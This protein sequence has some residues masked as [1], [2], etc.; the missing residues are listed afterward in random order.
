MKSKNLLAGLTC[1]LISVL[2]FG[3]NVNAE[4]YSS[5]K[6]TK[7]GKYVV[8][9]YD[10]LDWDYVRDA[11]E[12]VFTPEKTGIYS[13]KSSVNGTCK[14]MGINLTRDGWDGNITSNDSN[15]KKDLSVTKKVYLE[16]GK[17]YDIFVFIDENKDIKDIDFEIKLEKEFA[18]GESFV[19]AVS[20]TVTNDKGEVI[21]FENYKN[22][23]FSWDKKTNTVTLNNCKMK[24]EIY[25]KANTDEYDFDNHS[26]KPVLTINVKGTNEL[27]SL[28]DAA[29]VINSDDSSIRFVGEG[30][31]KS[32]LKTDSLCYTSYNDTV[33][34]FEN[35]GVECDDLCVYEAK[36]VV[37]NSVIK[38]KTNWHEWGPDD[39]ADDGESWVRD[40]ESDDERNKWVCDY[41]YIT[42]GG[43]SLINSEIEIEFELLPKAY[44]GKNFKNVIVKGEL[45]GELDE[46]T[47]SKIIVKAD[48][49]VIK[50]IKNGNIKIADKR[51]KDIVYKE[52]KSYRNGPKKGSII[53]GEKKYSKKYKEA[54]VRDG[55]SYR[56]IKSASTDG[57][58]I[59]KVYVSDY[60]L[61]DRKK[62]KKIT[63]DNI[64]YSHGCRYKVVG[65]DKKA[66]SNMKK[67]KKVVI[68]AKSIKKIGKK[69]FARKGG[70]KITFVLPK[71]Q[72]NKYVKLLKKTKV[73][74]FKV[75]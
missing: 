52:L 22:K 71:K 40:F 3:S 61:R 18:K 72:K 53:F 42:L 30:K 62:I 26:I 45:F 2:A 8:T 75:A 66:F 60:A 67:L 1:G 6:I 56:V 16:K 46:Y 13:L 63:I 51:V 50:S 29:P 73:K 47:N 74:K 49:S 17:K 25:A 23:G 27:L 20:G 65:I 28:D 38:T 48:K 58:K 68:K 44:L 7:E 70:N 36:T 33:L 39:D 24:C 14:R 9:D 31:S 15:G 21:A 10:Q 43:I 64:I 12:M 41:S 19:P 5:M 57:K 35:I 34:T 69:A 55:L 32:C 59:G 4:N 54:L 11:S 37:K